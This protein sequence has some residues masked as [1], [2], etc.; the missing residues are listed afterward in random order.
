M[1]VPCFNC[2][3]HGFWSHQICGVCAGSG[4]LDNE[5]K[6][7][8][9]RPAIKHAADT[10]VCSLQACYEKAVAEASGRQRPIAGG[11][12][13]LSRVHVDNSFCTCAM[14]PGIHHEYECRMKAFTEDESL[15]PLTGQMV[16]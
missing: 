14:I 12:V 2:F 10:V 1:R 15:W 5:L 16:N 11:F 7:H 3:G 9:G 4:H 8:C 13:P 6:C